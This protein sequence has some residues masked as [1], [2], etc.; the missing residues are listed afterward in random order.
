MIDEQ[1]PLENTLD[2]QES[3]STP[4]ETSDQ[5]DSISPND[6][7]SPNSS[8]STATSAESSVIEEVQPETSTVENSLETENSYLTEAEEIISVLQQENANLKKLLDEQTEQNNNTKAQYARLA[9]DFD[10]FRRRTSKEKEN[11][12]LQ[13]K[14]S[15]ITELLPVIDNFERARTQIKPNDEGEQTIHNSYQGVYKTLVDCLK[16]MGVAAMRPE[17]EQFDPNFHEAMLREATNEHPEGTV[18]EQLMRGY[19]LED[20]VLRHAMVKVAVP[21]EPMITS[22]E[23]TAKLED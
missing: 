4:S 6:L 19:L 22:E 3:I 15:I 23:E 20:Q 16:R 13:T 18:I 7:S 14:K 1:N 17:G 8:V 21:K 5:N 11:L 12:E 10:N 2:N 9:A